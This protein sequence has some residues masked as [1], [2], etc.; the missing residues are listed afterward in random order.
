MGNCELGRF[1]EA[2]KNYM[3]W[4]SKSTHF[5]AEAKLKRALV[6]KKIGR[7]GEVKGDLSKEKDQENEG[8]TGKAAG[9]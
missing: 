8:S 3:I 1:G 7:A 5:S 4:F 2:V 9:G 6:M